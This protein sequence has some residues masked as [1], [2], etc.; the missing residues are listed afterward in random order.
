MPTEKRSGA[1]VLALMVA[2]NGR[3]DSRE[4][5]ALDNLDAYRRIGVGREEFIEL[6]QTCL[7]DVG[8]HLHE[9]SWLRTADLVYID[10]LLD[11]VVDPDLRLLVCRLAAAAI[12]ADGAVTN[13]ERMVYDHALARWRISQS[14][15]SRAILDDR[16]P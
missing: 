13:D 4:L 14:M 10:A 9:N 3:I 8:A 11:K 1:R 2:A 15:V 7:K 12:T 6:A 16:S 5:K